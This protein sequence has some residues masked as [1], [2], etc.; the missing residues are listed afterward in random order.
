MNTYTLIHAY[1]L[2]PTHDW[3][4]IPLGLGI[5]VFGLALVFLF[6]AET[7]TGRTVAAAITAVSVVAIA[8]SI[9]TVAVTDHHQSQASERVQSAVAGELRSRYT[10]DDVRP[11]ATNYGILGGNRP[12][13]VLDSD[14]TV[15]DWNNKTIT[16]DDLETMVNNPLTGNKPTVVVSTDDNTRQFLYQLTF[17]GH[18]HLVLLPLAGSKTTPDPATLLRR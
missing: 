6:M 15:G 14:C 11:A 8:I 4:G 13:A 1:T 2:V 7:R 16:T 9:T 17:D 3:I 10:I 12:C 18:H 5:P